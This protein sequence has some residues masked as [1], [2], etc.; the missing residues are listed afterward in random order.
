MPT[1]Q[2]PN[3]S[4]RTSQADGTP[5]VHQAG[6]GNAHPARRPSEEIQSG[7]PDRK[8]ARKSRR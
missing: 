8:P 6:V 7:A 3:S 4:P 5:E 1:A 2:S